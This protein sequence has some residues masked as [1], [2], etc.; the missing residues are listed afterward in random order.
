VPGVAD[1]ALVNFAGQRS[2]LAWV[3]HGAAAEQGT[4]DI[5]ESAIR[6]GC[7]CWLPDVLACGESLPYTPSA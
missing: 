7:A 5:R 3:R 1:A 2:G 4:A 6:A